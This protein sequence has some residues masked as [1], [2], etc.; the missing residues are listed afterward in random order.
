[1]TTCESCGMPIETGRYCG[2]CTDETGQLQSLTSDSSGWSPG[3]PGVTWTPPAK[4]Y[5]PDP[6]LHGHHARLA[7]PPPRRRL[8]QFGAASALPD[9]ADQGN[10]GAV[11]EVIV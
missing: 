1:M 11:G 2:Y 6:R 10:A 3:R 5:A 8:A 4:S 9:G 7:G